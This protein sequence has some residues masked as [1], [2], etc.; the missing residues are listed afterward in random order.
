MK[1]RITVTFIIAFIMMQLFTPTAARAADDENLVAGMKYTVTYESPIDKAYPNLVFSDPGYALTDG[2]KASDTYSDSAYA[3]FY[4]G[5]YATVEFAFDS[6]VYV[7][8]FDVGFFGNAYGILIPREVY[9]SVS[10]DGENWYFVQSSRDDSQP[11]L[12]VKKRY[13]IS[14]T[15]TDHYKARYARL[16]FSCD[17]FC[18][19]DEIEIYG[20]RS[21][22]GAAPFIRDEKSYT[23]AF[24]SPDT[25]ILQG[26]RHVVLMYNNSEDTNT[27]E[28]LLP[29]AAYLDN[30]G[31]VVSADMFDSFL[32]LPLRYSAKPGQTDKEGWEEYL[33]ATLGFGDT[34]R[35]LAALEKTAETVGAA[36]GTEPPTYNVFLSIPQMHV[37]DDIFGYFEGKGNLRSNSKESRLYIAKWY[38][39]LVLEK[40]NACNFKHLNFVGFYWFTELIDFSESSYE[41]EFVKEYNEYVHS[42]GVAS[43]WIPYYCSPGFNYWRE[44]GFDCAALQSG[45]AFPRAEDSETG[46]QIAGMTDDTMAVAKKYGMAL[47]LEVASA[48]TERFAD[49]I[50][51][52]AKAGCMKDGISMY[53][54]EALPGVFYKFYKTDRSKYDLLHR[55]INATYEQY[56][57]VAQVPE[58]ILIK[59]DSKDNTGNLNFSDPDT[60]KTKIKLAS[61][62]EPS[63]GTL[64]LDRDGFF[65]YTPE[66]G[67]S[68][69]DSFTFSLTD[70]INVSE[71]YTVHILVSPDVVRFDGIN[72]RLKENKAVLYDKAGEATSA[73]PS[74]AGLCELVIDENGVITEITSAGGA[75]VP[76]GGYV[77]S[78]CG[79]RAKDFTKIAVPGNKIRLDTV[80]KSLYL[81]EDE[82]TP[83][84]SDPELS[85]PEG[86]GKGNNTVLYIAVA[87][88]AAAVIAAAAIIIKTKFKKGEKKE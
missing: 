9:L 76:Q 19:C 69:E 42:K 4:R 12:N 83:S 17:V 14:V 60:V 49:Y 45:W 86:S 36:L 78:Y 24:T 59:T 65:V 81:I 34:P 63:H 13:R 8:G 5:T 64:S 71:I 75:V 56:A 85:A 32:F 51:S 68:G 22:G 1:K 33:D 3:H 62:T 87:A 55:Y 29:Y 82:K 20:T 84:E 88:A 31:N 50:N 23:N 21:G 30:K 73:D 7:S 38:V 61:R 41:F 35:N 79:D 25:P 57:P 40:F 72:S 6:E 10:E 28:A 80:T 46:A 66:A 2:K 48:A 70:A 53:Y 74:L 11:S 77:L 47:E 67:Y 54:Q 26:T 18:Y 37:S 39:D 27:E 16:T 43:V 15:S 44:L 58:V 52:A